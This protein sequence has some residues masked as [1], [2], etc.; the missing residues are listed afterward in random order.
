MPGELSLLYLKLAKC[1]AE[2][3]A[4]TSMVIDLRLIVSGEI[5]FLRCTSER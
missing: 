5:P 1:G 2:T 4:E 3:L